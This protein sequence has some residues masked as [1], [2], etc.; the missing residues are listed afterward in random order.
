MHHV[1]RP[2]G[3]RRLPP[4]GPSSRVGGIAAGFTLVELLITMAVAAILLV[5]AV[6]SFRSLIASNELTTAANEMI[7]SLNLARME[8]I[9]RNTYTQFCSDSA[10]NN[11]SDTLGTECTSA[12]AGAV[13]VLA[14]ASSALEVTAVPPRLTPPVQLHGHIVAI[15]FDANGLG[16]QA[17]TSTPYTSPTA[18]PLADICTSSISTDNHIQIYMT[19]GTILTTTPASGACP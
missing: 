2:G 4:G 16:Y 18:S 6:P 5:I 14:T 11:T 8:A 17:G 3:C 1:S 10:S 15:R 19:T 12:G 13:A 9:K 7:G